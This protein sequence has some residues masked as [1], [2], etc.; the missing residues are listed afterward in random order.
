MIWLVWIMPRCRIDH[1]TC[2]PACYHCTMA[3]YWRANVRQT[4]NQH[5]LAM[6]HHFLKHH[7]S[8]LHHF[9][10]SPGEI[11]STI[12]LCVGGQKTAHGLSLCG[13]ISWLS[14][15]LS[16]DHFLPLISCKTNSWSIL[17]KAL[18]LQFACGKVIEDLHIEMCWV[19]NFSL[20]IYLFAD[21]FIHS[22]IYCFWGEGDVFIQ[23]ICL[24][25]NE[26]CL[27]F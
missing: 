25:G 4:C 10:T 19:S 1:L 18:C 14:L 6:Q 27:L 26:T 5:S 24:V 23:T 15:E 7:Y 17:Q 8:F 21:L 22:F 20:L 12:L 2:S 11:P 16:S 13:F 9:A 3:A